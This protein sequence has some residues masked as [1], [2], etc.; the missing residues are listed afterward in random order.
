MPDQGVLTTWEQAPAPP[1]LERRAAVR[2]LCDLEAI[3]HP[4]E[5][6]AMLSW[7]A[8]IEN[9]SRTGVGVVVGYP[10]RPESLLAVEVQAGKTVRTLLARVV[11]VT[12]Q[13]GGWF[14]GCE[15]INPLNENELQALLV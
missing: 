5:Q 3:T 15:F 11:H 6:P 8:R 13:V 2:Y 7:G 10:F 1:S 9:L 4:L 12:D 14:L